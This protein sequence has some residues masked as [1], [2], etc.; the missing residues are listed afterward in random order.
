MRPSIEEYSMMTVTQHRRENAREVTTPTM[1]I[2]ILKL[3][4]IDDGEEDQANSDVDADS[5][6]DE[7]GFEEVEASY[8]DKDGDGFVDVDW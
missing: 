8:D 6:Y 4:V 7:N 5:D 2:L 3:M 1:L